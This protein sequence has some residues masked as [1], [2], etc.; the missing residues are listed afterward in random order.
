VH[1]SAIHCA[2]L[3]EQG[4]WQVTHQASIRKVSLDELRTQV[5]LTHRPEPGDRL[6]NDP[7]ETVVLCAFA[8]AMND[9]H[10]LGEVLQI[11]L[12][13][14]IK[15]ARMDAGGVLLLEP[16]GNE[17]LLKAHIGGPPDLVRTSGCVKVDEG[18]MPRMLA[19]VLAA[20]QWA[21][22]TEKRRL[23]LEQS[24]VESLLSIPLISS[25]RPQGVMIL[26]SEQRHTFDD[27]ELGFYA[28]IGRHVGSALYRIDLQT[29]ELRTAILE[30][31]QAMARQMHD[32]IAQT[33]AC[34][35]LRVDEMM[36]HPELVGIAHVQIELEA[37]RRAIERAYQ[38]VRASIARLSRDIPTHF[39]LRVALQEII[40]EFER[41][42]KRRVEMQVDVDWMAPLS[43]LAA[44]Q[45]SYIIQEALNNTR[46]HAQ[47][48]T[49]RLALRRVEDQ[50]IE[51]LVQDDGQGFDFAPPP[52]GLGSGSSE[53][54]FGLRFMAER[55]KRV[56]G[57]LQV[58]SE[59]GQGTKVIVR[60]PFS[61][62][63]GTCNR[64][65]F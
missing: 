4:D 16:S 44:F 51:L 39:D 3:T 8:E 38:R 42:T 36:D 46:K 11:A 30:E 47:A 19:S 60:L 9:A 45:A 27:T 49:I 23:A 17:L 64:Q 52:D 43:P 29:Q 57:T 31:R 7:S 54:G 59:P 20:D 1:P 13:T 58:K 53:D 21:D 24:G 12:Q 10:D 63:G 65:E 22:V 50:T 55:A 40:D 37:M 33:L 14:T 5:R 61:Q 56:G 2:P 41:T 32:D 6:H 62:G 25:G 35:G 15:L 18:L 28:I 48:R 26:V 34:L